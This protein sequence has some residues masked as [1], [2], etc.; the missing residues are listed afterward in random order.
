MIDFKCRYLKTNG[1]P[2]EKLDNSN[3]ENYQATQANNQI[4][5]NNYVGNANPVIEEYESPSSS[6][7]KINFESNIKVVNLSRVSAKKNTDG[8]EEKKGSSK[9]PPSKLPPKVVKQSKR[10]LK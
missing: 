4:I 9:L 3:V 5:H 7:R 1:E 8:K 6:P 2:N 10:I